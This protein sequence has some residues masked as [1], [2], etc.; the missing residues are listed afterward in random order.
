MAAY[1]RLSPTGPA[2]GPK[3]RRRWPVVLVAGIC[4][5][6][7]LLTLGYVLLT[8]RPAGYL[9]IPPSND[10]QVNPYL[11]HEL[12]PA[13]YNNIQIDKPFEV[14][15]HQDKLN[16]LVADGRDL[17]WTW[18]VTVSGVTFSAPIV[19]FEADRITLMGQVDVGVPIVVTITAQPELDA[20]GRLVMNFRKIK[21]GAINIT[22]P[23][24]HIAGQIML[25]QAATLKESDWLRDLAAACLENAPYDPKFPVP[26]YEKYIRLTGLEL[27]PGRLRLRFDPAGP[28][29]TE[30]AQRGRQTGR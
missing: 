6:A 10:D 1:N 26:A 20:E 7:V 15:V 14:I 16:Q 11:T 13:F 17:G 18:P 22:G 28:M 9:P 27:G 2:P 12:A 30:T 29:P 4:L 5:L 8:Y 23:A 21:A 3:H 25:A 19:R 24:R